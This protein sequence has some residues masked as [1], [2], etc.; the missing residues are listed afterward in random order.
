MVY[1]LSSKS[2]PICWNKGCL[3]DSWGLGLLLFL[4]YKNDL[5]N[6][7]YF[8]KFESFIFFRSISPV[9]GEPSRSPSP[10]PDRS[11]SLTDK[12]DMH[13]ECDEVN[14]E[15]T[16]SIEPDP[17][18]VAPMTDESDSFK[19]TSQGLE[20]ENKETVEK[21]R[22]RLEVEKL[23]S[24]IDEDVISKSKNNP[25][26]G[27]ESSATD[28]SDEEIGDNDLD[29][30]LNIAIMPS[31]SCKDQ[32]KATIDNEIEKEN[33]KREIL[34]I[35]NQKEKGCHID[36]T[37]SASNNEQPDKNKEELQ[38]NQDEGKGDDYI[39]IFAESDT[40]LRK[41]KSDNETDNY[42]GNQNLTS[43]DNEINAEYLVDNNLSVKSSNVDIGHFDSN[44]Y[45]APFADP[46]S[47]KV[48]DDESRKEE[49]DDFE[50]R[51]KS[52]SDIRNSM[53]LMTKEELE[54]A[55][56][57]LPS[58]TESE[59][60]AIDGRNTPVHLRDIQIPLV[61]LTEY[62]EDKNFLYKQVFRNINKKEFK[63]MLPKYLRVWF[64]LSI[65]I[66][67]LNSTIITVS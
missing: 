31:N 63:F 64:I 67:D 45:V 44:N 22:L 32:I 18:G 29:D 24:A 20:E 14:H 59:D 57:K 55:L 38:E 23:E 13:N 10:S 35:I 12:A 47:V 7:T 61:S 52:L 41:E 11:V 8:Q 51:L 9:D 65:Y 49:S 48:N 33:L 3:L 43:I 58:L 46:L 40:E 4:I 19:N 21:E 34:E 5:P 2:L 53:S 60:L 1:F 39:D 30:N 66:S 25:N 15:I 16:D 56:K 6:S 50:K 28:I 26:A 27:S 54:E 17:P 42:S 36:K 62:V 37:V